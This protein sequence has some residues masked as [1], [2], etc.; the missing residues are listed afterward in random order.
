M[1]LHRVLER[2]GARA[3]SAHLR[4]LCDYLAYDFAN[5]GQNQ[6]INKRVDAV[7]DLIWKYNVVTLDR[8]VLCLVWFSLNDLNIIE[9]VFD[10]HKFY[11]QFEHKRET[12]HKFVFILFN[13]F[14]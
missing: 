11:R 5:S 1:L 8:L 14:C 3:L 13:Y 4:K 6:N 9:Y 12:R 10:I 2:I 7:N